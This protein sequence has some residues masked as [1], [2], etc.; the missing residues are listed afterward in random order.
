MGVDP[1]FLRSRADACDVAV[2][3][4]RMTRGAAMDANDGL[5][6]AA[7]G[8]AFAQSIDDMQ[9]RWEALVKEVTGRLDTASDNF[10]ISADAYEEN[11]DRVQSS[12]ANIYR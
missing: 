10:R 3:T 6:K 8:W 7:S 5:S 9:S 1:S 2:E 4:I 12:F 11:E